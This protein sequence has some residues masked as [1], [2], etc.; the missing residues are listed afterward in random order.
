[1]WRLAA[2]WKLS[3][4]ARPESK[5]WHTYRCEVAEYVINKKQ[6]GWPATGVVVH[7]LAVAFAQQNIPTLLHN[8][9]ILT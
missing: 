8:I 3:R 4:W 2:R 9:S 1:M 6:E 7:L 5:L